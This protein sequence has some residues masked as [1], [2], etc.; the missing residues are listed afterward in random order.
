LIGKSLLKKA[1]FIVSSKKEQADIFT[2][3]VA[4]EKNLI[5]VPNIVE[6]PDVSNIEHSALSDKLRIIFL[7]RIEQKK[8]LEFLIDALDMVD[9]PV[10]LDIYGAGNDAYIMRVKQ[11]AS[12]NRNAASIFFHGPVYGDEKFKVLAHHDVFVLP[13]Y[14]ENFANVVLE[15]MSVGTLVVLTEEVGLADVVVA[16]GKGLLIRRDAK[17]IARVLENVPQKLNKR[18]MNCGLSDWLIELFDPRQLAKRHLEY[19]AFA[20]N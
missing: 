6:F 1:S 3:G 13:S 5:I 20:K 7:S 14:D 17:N 16:N 18:Q 12:T 10:V 15:C 2:L 8:G 19:Y 11:R 9:F 4:T